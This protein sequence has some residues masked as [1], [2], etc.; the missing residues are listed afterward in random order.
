MWTKKRDT[1]G[2]KSGPTSRSLTTRSPPLIATV[3]CHGLILRRIMV[4]I[5]GA[6]QADGPEPRKRVSHFTLGFF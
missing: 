5:D 6:L 4:S 1:G 3:T 2:L